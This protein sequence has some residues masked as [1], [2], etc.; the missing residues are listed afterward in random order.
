[1]ASWPGTSEAGEARGWS[2]D[3][4]VTDG[5]VAPRQLGG[6]Y[7]VTRRVLTPDQEKFSLQTVPLGMLRVP[8][9][10]SYRSSENQ[11][12]SSSNLFSNGLNINTIKLH[13][14]H[15]IKVKVPEEWA[16]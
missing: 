6:G 8:N 9:E 15:K 16:N 1:M 4:R 12:K 11:E 2:R 13:I 10:S 5:C 14:L 3:L 7:D